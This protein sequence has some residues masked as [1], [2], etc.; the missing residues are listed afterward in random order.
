MNS[1]DP[2]KLFQENLRLFQE[3][4]RLIEEMFI[5]PQSSDY[6][7]TIQLGKEKLNRISEKDGQYAICCDEE[8]KLLDE[9]EEKGKRVK[10]ASSTNEEKE[11]LFED[12]QKLKSKIKKEN[13]QKDRSWFYNDRNDDGE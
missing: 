7:R 13:M 2:K 1:K 5:L 9:V 4:L 6:Q 3:N 10:K 8:I 12:L 11:K